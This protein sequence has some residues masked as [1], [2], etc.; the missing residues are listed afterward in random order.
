MTE[1]E[2]LNQHKRERVVEWGVTLAN[3]LCRAL[4]KMPEALG[5]LPAPSNGSGES[6]DNWTPSTLRRAIEVNLNKAAE[7]VNH[8]ALKIYREHGVTLTILQRYDSFLDNPDLYSP[9]PRDILNRGA[10]FPNPLDPIA[11]AILG[12]SKNIR[13]E[14]SRITEDDLKETLNVLMSMD[15]KKFVSDPQY[16]SKMYRSMAFQ[17]MEMCNSSRLSFATDQFLA[18]G[19]ISLCREYDSDLSF[20]DSISKIIKKIKNMS[21]N[22]STMNLMVQQS[23]ESEAKLG[24]RDFDPVIVFDRFMH[25]LSKGQDKVITWLAENTNL[26]SIFERIHELSPIEIEPNAIVLSGRKPFTPLMLLKAV[27]NSNIFRDEPERISPSFTAS[28]AAGMDTMVND[29][30]HIFTL[31]SKYEKSGH[32]DLDKLAE[33]NDEL[34]KHTNCLG[35][36]AAMRLC[37]GHVLKANPAALARVS[38][39]LNEDKVATIA[40]ASEETMKR[41][42][43]DSFSGSYQAKLGLSMSDAFANK[44]KLTEL[45]ESLE[46]RARAFAEDIGL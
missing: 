38:Q 9:H 17:Y 37:K 34:E 8:E 32:L 30:G 1:L 11:H 25:A 15:G 12:Y 45:T 40:G 22:S 3:R 6:K 27:D 28:M 31:I 21:F 39:L 44:S 23:M 46:F 33:F 19:G 13:Y 41:L 14:G 24:I 42:F 16:V 29:K 10:T 36:D 43:V 26:R 18:A 35:I 2:R 5:Y 20:D 4:G 7:D